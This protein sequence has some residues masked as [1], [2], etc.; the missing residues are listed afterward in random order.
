V[1]FQQFTF[2]LYYDQL[3]D[4]HLGRGQ[5]EGQRVCLQGVIQTLFHEF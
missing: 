2:V 1:S 4:H 5:R 3:F